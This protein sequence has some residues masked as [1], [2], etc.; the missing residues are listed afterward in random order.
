MSLATAITHKPDGTL[1]RMPKARSGDMVLVSQHADFR[2]PI[3]GWIITANNSSN[4]VSIFAMADDGLVPFPVGWHRTDPR[5]QSLSNQ[6]DET[7]GMGVWDFAP[8]HMEQQALRK[9]VADMGATI[10]EL[11]RTLTEK[12]VALESVVA[13]KAKA[14]RPRT[15]TAR[16]Q[17]KAPSEVDTGEDS[18]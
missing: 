5:C 8:A 14:G 4:V 2:K 16:L 18:N 7:G 11:E 12:I 17:P 10:R 15:A 6:I 13:K 3:T 9:M 1:F